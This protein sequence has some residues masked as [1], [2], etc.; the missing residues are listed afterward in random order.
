[1]K[2]ENEKY[3]INN[4]DDNQFK[5]YL[6]ENEK[7]CLSSCLYNNEELFLDEENKICYK[8]VS[9]TNKETIQTA[10]IESSIIENMKTDIES[11][12]FDTIKTDVESSLF[13]TIKIEGETNNNINSEIE[14]YFEIIENKNTPINENND[15]N[16]MV[17][18]YIRN[19]DKNSELE[20]KIIRN[21][22]IISF[23]ST[24]SDID[25]LISLNPNLTYVNLKDCKNLLINE[26]KLDQNSD[27]LIIG[28]ETIKY[29]ENS[30]LN[31]FN[32][33]IYTKTGDKISNLSICEN[34][35]IEISSPITNLDIINY[36]EALILFEQG[37]DIYNYSS[38]FYY[39]VCLSAYINGSDLTLSVRQ[40]EIYPNITLC[41][42]GC[43]YNG[44]DLEKKRVNCICNSNSNSSNEENS[45]ENLIE[46]VEQNFF[47]YI[48]D[49][50]N[51]QIIGCYKKIS[52]K[53]NYI[54]NFGFYF[55]FC[56][57]FLISI[58][59]LSYC[60]TGQKSIKLQYFHKEPNL[61]KIRLQ[62]INF[63]KIEDTK[64]FLSNEGKIIKKSRKISKLKTKTSLFSNPISNPLKKKKSKKKSKKNKKWRKKSSININLKIDKL[65]IQNKQSN[66]FE[67]S[68]ENYKKYTLS[69]RAIINTASDNKIEK[70]D[71]NELSYID[72]FEQDKRNI[73]QI[74][75][76]LFYLKLKTI[77]IL[78]YRNE[79]S[80]LSLSLSL[81]FFEI[82]LDVTINSL[83]FSDD[84]ISQKYFNNGELLFI[85]TNILSISSNII[86]FF[87]LLYTEK[88]INYY[89]VLDEI[90]KEIKDQNNYYK[91]YIKLKC[92]FRIKI[93]IFYIIL[94]FI[95]IFCTYYLFIFCAIYKNI[96]KNLV[97]NYII[98]TLWSLG[99]T[100]FICLLVTIT[101]KIAIKNRIKRLYIISK[102][103]DDKF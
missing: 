85:T 38:S 80:H 98:G 34:S 14:Y 79:F 5:Y 42:E 6:N 53:S 13:N 71:Y 97:I 35:N 59:M 67:I 87:I 52:D 81:Y 64:K 32:Y 10:F 22:T 31:D 46:E 93:F 18:N 63:N 91:I 84:V 48:V 69:N 78:F 29:S 16:S 15:I 9:Q 77:Q 92:C 66:Y 82:L 70:I 4:C 41:Q 33:E 94:F 26:N 17:E 74:F 2:N 55:S 23:Y 45:I 28:I 47:T 100:I 27:L 60:F 62:E 25:T 90:T 56:L 51:Y 24:Q 72:A 37:Y 20:V 57:I 88:L 7:Y 73:F 65:E 89:L 49:M 101:R 54:Y 21:D 44:F 39:D 19:K 76:S 58:L 83:L 1:M 68:N 12:I 95:G 43:S 61:K 30:I 102:F 50:I 11:S 3:C 99:F 8:N 96:Q 86:S 75:L 40:Q 103:I 36:N